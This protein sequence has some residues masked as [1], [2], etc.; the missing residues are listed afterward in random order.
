MSNLIINVYG[1]FDIQDNNQYIWKQTFNKSVYLYTFMIDNAV[2]DFGYAY[3]KLF[4]FNNKYF[5]NYAKTGF[6]K[7]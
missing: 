3:Y 2:S 6:H 5:K 1:R 4:I 7:I